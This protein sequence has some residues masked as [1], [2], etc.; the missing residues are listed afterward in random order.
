MWEIPAIPNC[1]V[2]GARNDGSHKCPVETERRI[3]AGRKTHDD[4][5]DYGAW[6]G[7]KL[8]DGFRFYNE[9]Y[10]NDD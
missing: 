5:A 10:N 8:C 6:Y 4:R 3:E 2:C 7:T 9:D 1:V